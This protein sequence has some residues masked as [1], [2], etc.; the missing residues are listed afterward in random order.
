MEENKEKKEFELVQVPT[1]MGLAVKT[2]EEETISESE[3]LV[4]IANDVKEIK[5]ELLK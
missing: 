4:K 1:Q 3:L 5:E 2:P